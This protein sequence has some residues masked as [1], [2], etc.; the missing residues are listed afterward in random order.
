MSLAGNEADLPRGLLQV[1]YQVKSRRVRCP[2]LAFGG[3]DEATGFHSRACCSRVSAMNSTLAGNLT[4]VGSVTNLIVAERARSAGIDVSFGTYCLA[5]V[6]LTLLSLIF[7]AWW[8][9]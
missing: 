1:R 9:S 6:P 7:G 8:L 5:G 4:L 2:L 3:G